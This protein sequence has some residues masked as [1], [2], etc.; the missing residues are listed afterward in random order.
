MEVSLLSSVDNMTTENSFL[1]SF[2][3]HLLFE[4]HATENNCV[5]LLIGNWMIEVLHF[6]LPL[7][8][9]VS[10]AVVN[11]GLIDGVQVLHSSLPGDELVTTVEGCLVIEG[12]T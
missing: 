5:D 11:K 1:S 3:I 6:L 2:K 10:V 7:V 8:G 9:N 12:N 4:R